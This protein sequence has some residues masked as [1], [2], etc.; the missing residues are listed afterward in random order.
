MLAFGRDGYLY[1][2]TGDGGGGGDPFH[3][4]QDR[5]SL[6]GKLLRID[7]RHSCSG[8]YYC[9]P[10]N[11]P[12]ARSKVYRKEIWAYGLRNAWRFSVDKA[13]GDLWVADVGQN[14]YEEVTRIPYGKKAWNLGWSCREGK[15]VFNASP[16]SAQVTYHSPTLE[17]GH[18]LGE[19]IIGGLRLSRDDVRQAA[20]WA[21]T[22]TA[23]T[24]AD[25]SGST[26]AASAVRLA[27]SVRSG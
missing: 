24:R 25:A 1:L 14:K 8:K 10:A 2:T 18:S 6:N 12:Y 16:C 11:N 19:A 26:G 21:C 9:I 22:S 15:H 7:A 17:Y 23:T 13:N 4:A 3:H 27:R 20:A 5:K